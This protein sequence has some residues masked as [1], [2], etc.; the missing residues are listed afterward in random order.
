MTEF[1]PLDYGKT[2][3]LAKGSP[4]P[5]LSDSCLLGAKYRVGARRCVLNS[6]VLKK[7]CTV[8]YFD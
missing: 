4:S 8:A 1:D 7:Y 6:G 2:V 3:A 5:S